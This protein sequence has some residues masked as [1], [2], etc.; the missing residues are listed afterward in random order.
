MRL[1]ARPRLLRQN[2]EMKTQFVDSDRA[3]HLLAEK[4]GA[5]VR[6]DRIPHLLQ[7]PGGDEIEVVVSESRLEKAVRQVRRV[8]RHSFTVLE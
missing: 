4:M 8:G 1:F 6:H 7:L 5:V 3:K 2:A